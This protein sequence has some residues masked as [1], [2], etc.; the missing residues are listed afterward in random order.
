MKY[1]EE[2]DFSNDS[3][4]DSSVSQHSHVSCDLIVDNTSLIN[5][6]NIN[7]GGGGIG[8]TYPFTVSSLLLSIF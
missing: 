4:N 7:N 5:N 3:T 8:S 6:I 2:S 1:E